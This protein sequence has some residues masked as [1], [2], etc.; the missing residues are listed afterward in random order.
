MNA[1]KLY[2]DRML[3]EISKLVQRILNQSGGGGGSTLSVDAVDALDSEYMDIIG[4]GRYTL[5][6]ASDVPKGTRR[7][8]RISDTFASTIAPSILTTASDKI[9]YSGGEANEFILNGHVAIEA[10]F[11]SDGISKWR[12]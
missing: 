4:D 2:K 7:V 1:T 10:I 9:T 11:V 6:A 12:L 5:P 8:V 3:N